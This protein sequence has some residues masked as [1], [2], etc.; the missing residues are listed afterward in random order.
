MQLSGSIIAHARRSEA[1]AA[2][3][4]F[5]NPMH[6]HTELFSCKIVIDGERNIIFLIAPPWFPKAK[7]GQYVMQTSICCRCRIRSFKS[8]KRSVECSGS[9]Q[10]AENGAGR[11]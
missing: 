11:H 9:S 10:P 5:M 2:G 3:D 7:S 4:C 6:Q 8:A 1:N